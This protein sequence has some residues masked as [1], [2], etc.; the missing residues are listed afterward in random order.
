MKIEIE[1]PDAVEVVVRPD[2]KGNPVVVLEMF[3]IQ[4]LYADPWELKKYGYDIET[5]KDVFRSH[6]G[7]ILAKGLLDSTAHLEGRPWST[8]SPTGREV[9]ATGTID[10][11]EAYGL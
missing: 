2:Y 4:V 9:Q 3:G 10:L 1:I 5:W 11:T 8:K 6:L 7:H